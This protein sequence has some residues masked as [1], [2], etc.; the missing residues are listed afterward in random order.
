MQNGCY[1][2]ALFAGL[3]W[4]VVERA[5]TKNSRKA[6]TWKFGAWLWKI[7]QTLW[8]IKYS[9]K[10][11][12]I[13]R[14]SWNSE[15]QRLWYVLVFKLTTILDI[16]VETKQKIY[17]SVKKPLSPKINVVDKVLGFW[18][19]NSARFNIDIGG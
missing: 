6:V 15:C 1:R 13:N 18:Q 14:R 8:L 3:L 4:R 2:Y 11:V 9:S 12:F 17:F 19:Q 5:F 10:F 16:T 7:I